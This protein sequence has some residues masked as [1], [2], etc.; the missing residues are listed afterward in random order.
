M[1]EIFI[2]DFSRSIN[3]GLI[4][5]IDLVTKFVIAKN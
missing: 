4:S 5:I 2:L 3:G 1:I